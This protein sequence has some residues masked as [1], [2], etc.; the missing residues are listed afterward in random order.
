MASKRQIGLTLLELVVVVS[1]L[2]IMTAILLPAAQAARESARRTTCQSNLRQLGI[3]AI[4]FE[5]VTGYFPGP[6][7]DA[8]PGSL[9]YRNDRGLFPLLS[10][11][12][13]LPA[14]QDPNSTFRDLNQS[15][16]ESTR[17]YCGALRLPN[18]RNCFNYRVRFPAPQLSSSRKHAIMLETVELMINAERLA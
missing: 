6:D 8:V 15:A 16:L 13:E 4:N 1:M 12:L 5:S 10:S 9:V 17:K 14:W 18:Q 3:A 2:G 11:F 7:F